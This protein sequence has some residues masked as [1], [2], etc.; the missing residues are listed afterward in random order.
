MLRC[1]RFVS[2]FLLAFVA[3]RSACLGA[4]VL[5]DWVCTQPDTIYDGGME[6]AETTV[7]H[8]PSSGTGGAYPGNSIRFLDSGNH[9][10]YVYVPSNYTPA[11]TWPLMLALEGAAGSAFGA[12][13]GAKAARSYWSTIAEA[14]GF[15]VI[16]PVPSGNY[17]GWTEPNPDGS[18]PSDYDVIAEAILD[19]ESAYNIER[20]RLY[21]WGF[22]AGGEVIHDIVLTGWIGMNADFFSAY[23]VASAVL[24]GCPTYYYPIQS[25]LP[26]RSV[27][28]IP[29]DIHVGSAESTMLP[30]ALNDESTFLADGWNVGT[31]LFFTEFTDG[32]P[33]GGH[34]YTTAHLAQVWTNLCPNAATP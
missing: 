21:A 11:R 22:S 5:P 2:F 31:N 24:A 8:S 14:N 32:S 1:V 7:P 29:L 13:S 16:A 17:G 20:T 30:Y 10:Y 6:A 25:C 18:G 15:I 19:T 27:R 4:A 3:A 9:S 23:A 33:A 12:I 34:T 26:T 28:T